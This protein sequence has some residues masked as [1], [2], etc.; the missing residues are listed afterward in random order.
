MPAHKVHEI[1][2]QDLRVRVDEAGDGGG[3][4]E[5]SEGNPAGEDDVD[6]H[7][8]ALAGSV[9]EDVAGG[10]VGAVVGECEGLVGD[11]EVVGGEE[12]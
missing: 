8:D 3:F 10:V 9:D 7:E 4:A 12:G 1:I 5:V 11:C 2:P 6:D